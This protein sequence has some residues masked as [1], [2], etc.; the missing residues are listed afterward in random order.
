MDKDERAAA[1]EQRAAARAAA[2]QHLGAAPRPVP[3]V[4][5]VWAIARG[6][7][8]AADEESTLWGLIVG[9]LVTVGPELVRWLLA[10][11]PFAG[12]YLLGLLGL[13]LLL[14]RDVPRGLASGWADQQVL[15]RGDVML[16]D[17]EPLRRLKRRRR[18]TGRTPG[19]A[20]GRGVHRI[21]LRVLDE[22]AEIDARGRLRA[23]RRVL[24][25]PLLALLL[26]GCAALFFAVALLRVVQWLL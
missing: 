19:L 22:V 18:A 10:I 4:L 9:S 15:M 1:I 20:L 8:D 24:V 11:E 2:A 16:D 13:V 12:L 23:R 21:D 7:L 25:A 6:V 26:V 5:R 3:L 14:F 17:G